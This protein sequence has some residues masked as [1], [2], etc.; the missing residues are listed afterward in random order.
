M[1]PSGTLLILLAATLTTSSYTYTYAQEPARRQEPAT[2]AE[3]L[4]REREDKAK[5]LAPPES[6][7]LERTLRDL[8]SGRLFERL[9]NPAEWLYPKMG[10]IT[11]G[12]GFSIGP[13]T[14]NPASLAGTRTSAGLPRFR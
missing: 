4:Q 13:G 9:L 11:S 7:R 3:T 14:G 6:N 1:R 12:S 10:N 5:D 2:R 8:E